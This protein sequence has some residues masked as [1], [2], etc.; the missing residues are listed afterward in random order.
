MIY[1]D[2]TCQ[3]IKEQNRQIRKAKNVLQKEY[4]KFQQSFV[5]VE[6]WF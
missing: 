1:Q 3:D 4:G 5:L 2:F 6:P